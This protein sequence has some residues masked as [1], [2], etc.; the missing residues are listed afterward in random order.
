MGQ[1]PDAPE[2]IETSTS[3]VSCDGGGTRGHPKVFLNM[4]KAKEVECPYCDC[5]FVLT[6]KHT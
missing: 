1:K 6:A 4:G 5:L 2:I 3:E